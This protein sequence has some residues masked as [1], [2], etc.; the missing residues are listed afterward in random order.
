MFYLFIHVHKLTCANLHVNGFSA[1]RVYITRLNRSPSLSPYDIT[2]NLK[3]MPTKRYALAR[4]SRL[5]QG[6][7]AVLRI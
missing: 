7:N 6:N 3:A 2:R 4:G 1:S 5:M